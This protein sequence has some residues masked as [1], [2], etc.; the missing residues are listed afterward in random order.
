MA[1]PSTGRGFFWL[2]GLERSL[3][4]VDA[5]V[6]RDQRGALGRI[7]QERSGEVEIRDG[8][9]VKGLL[10]GGVAADLG[11]GGCVFLAADG[12]DQLSWVGMVLRVVDEGRN[13]SM[14]PRPAGQST[15]ARTGAPLRCTSASTLIT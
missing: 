7:G 14:S 15:R 11:C 10:G 5:V 2:L 8:R 1:T 12:G 13:S 3:E 6:L 9:E 4:H